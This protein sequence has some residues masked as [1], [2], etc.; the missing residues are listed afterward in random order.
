MARTLCCLFDGFQGEVNALTDNRL[1]MKRL[2]SLRV[3]GQLEAPF[4]PALLLLPS[5]TG[6]LRRRNAR[7]FVLPFF[8][9]AVA[10]FFLTDYKACERQAV[11]GGRLLEVS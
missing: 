5:L 1:G 10:K 8:A 2:I 6:A 4:A 7:R 9:I 3:H 11:R